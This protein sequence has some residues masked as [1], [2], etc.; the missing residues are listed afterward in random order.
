MLSGLLFFTRLEK[1]NRE[2]WVGKLKTRI[3]SLLVPYLIWNTIAFFVYYSVQCFKVHGII[4]F[5]GCFLNEGGLGIF[6]N[7]HGGWMPIDFPLWFIRD[8]MAVVLVSPLVYLLVKKKWVGILTISVFAIFHIS[9][10]WPIDNGLSSKA[11]LFF[12][13]GAY[14][15]M[16]KK[17]VLTVFKP[18]EVLSY[19]L[20]GLFLIMIVLCWGQEFNSYIRSSFEIFVTM[21]TFIIA[22]RLSGS[23]TESFGCKLSKTSFWI[24]A[25]QAIYVI[26]ISRA[27]MSRLLPWNNYQIVNILHYLGTFVLATAICI[28]SYFL[29]NKIMPKTMKVLCGSR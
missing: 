4:S 6:W 11:V 21:A 17:D 15:Q 23:K 12:V 16:H 28:L 25:V 14:L 2:I 1:W 22:L 13:S 26:V 20:S 10:L 3:K 5:I 7:S 9:G 29:I 27:V 18:I 8:L 19:I 24:F